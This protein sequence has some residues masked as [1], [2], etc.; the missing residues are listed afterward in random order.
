MCRSNFHYLFCS[1]YWIKF[2]FG[3]NNKNF[4]VSKIS[5]LLCFV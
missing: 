2:H 4:R 5:V 3:M 1:I